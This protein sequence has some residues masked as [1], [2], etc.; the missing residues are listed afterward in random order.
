MSFF[1]QIIKFLVLEG[2]KKFEIKNFTWFHLRRRTWRRLWR[3]IFV[4]DAQWYDRNRRL[5]P[6]SKSSPTRRYKCRRLRPTS[7]TMRSPIQQQQQHKSM[8]NDR[9]AVLFFPFRWKKNPQVFAA[10]VLALWYITDDERFFPLNQFN[11]K[12]LIAIPST[13]K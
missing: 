5:L 1:P 7:R 12:V 9:S 10:Q 13:W 11:S 2:G 8:E 4:R 6:V 3:W